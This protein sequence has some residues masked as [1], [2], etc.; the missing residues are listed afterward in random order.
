[1]VCERSAGVLGMTA[2]ELLAGARETGLRVWE[3]GGR[4]HVRGPKA[5]VETVGRALL[6]RKAEVLAALAEPWDQQA[7]FRLLDVADELSMQLPPEVRHSIPCGD[8]FAAAEACDMAGVRAALG[9]YEAA[10]R[11]AIEAQTRAGG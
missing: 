10:L 3:D 8:I 5:A 1:M 7:A 4:L 6:D 2:V 11:R 9:R